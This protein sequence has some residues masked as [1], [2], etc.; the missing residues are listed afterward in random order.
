MTVPTNAGYPTAA[1]AILIGLV[2]SAQALA[3]PLTDDVSWL[4]HL[5]GRVLDGER[6]Y[7]DWLEINP[8]LIVWLGVPLVALARLLG[9][10]VAQLTPIAVA[11]GCA[12]AVVAC[13][14]WARGALSHPYRPA[15]AVAVVVTLFIVPLRDWGQREHVMMM[16]TL[17]YIVAHA[18][19]LRAG[20]SE[21]G[22]LVGIAAG[23]GFSIKPFFVLAFVGLEAWALYRTRRLW[24][25]AWA[26]GAVIAAYGIIVLALVPEYL[27][28]VAEQG[29]AY[30]A[31]SPGASAADTLNSPVVLGVALALLCVLVRGESRE[32]REALAIAT[33]AWLVGAL[34]QSGYMGYRALPALSGAA[35]LIMT[36]LIATGSVR[37]STRPAILGAG[38]LT[39]VY[40]L[41]FLSEA[42]DRRATWEHLQA[43]AG[44]IEGQRVAVLSPYGADAW[45][46]LSYADADPTFTMV[47]LWPILAL[48]RAD[49]DV[50]LPLAGERFMV[51][52]AVAALDSRPLV[53]VGRHGGHDPIR[54]LLRHDDFRD[55]WSG[56]EETDPLE[57][58]RVFRP[59]EWRQ[60]TPERSPAGPEW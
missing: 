41:L 31:F 29:A 4:L 28:M 19:R 11:A 9:V 25:G 10:S 50:A 49:G 56:Y 24:A 40:M 33:A 16:L 30:R 27:A 45:P 59:R 44:A 18:A 42:P 17:P 32:L 1:L 2:G 60:P 21:G 34:M 12:V 35:L 20:T 38:I 23:V 47:S 37:R 15:F 3:I 55:A 48:H 46:A 52:R 8:P 43:V 13:H 5:S 39:A 14:R 7:V 36:A 22:W 57:H 58:Y 54:V 51:S 6:L 26:A 53:L